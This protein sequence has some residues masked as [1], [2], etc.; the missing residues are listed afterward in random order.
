MKRKR[1]HQREGVVYLGELQEGKEG[2]ELKMVVR[3]SGGN[4][5]EAEGRKSMWSKFAD[6]SPSAVAQEAV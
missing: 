1:R 4:K 2:E 6:S 3:S 5:E